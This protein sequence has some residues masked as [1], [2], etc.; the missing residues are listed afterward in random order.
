MPKT[1]VLNLVQK[2]T[3]CI[4]SSNI[5]LK[6]TII[7]CTYVQLDMQVQK[8]NFYSKSFFFIFWSTHIEHFDEGCLLFAIPSMLVYNDLRFSQVNM[9]WDSLVSWFED[10]FNQTEHE[11]FWKVQKGQQS[12]A[13]QFFT[14]VSNP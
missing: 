9:Y 3:K 6:I 8:R 14:T 2:L 12:G 1:N 7:A 11:Q 10:E 4:S 13:M 5:L